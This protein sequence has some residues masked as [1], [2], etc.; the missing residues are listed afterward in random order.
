MQI[1]VEETGDCQLNIHY[2]A[3]Q[4]Q[5]LSKQKEVVS[6]FKKAPVKGFRK[7]KAPLN[8]IKNH[9]KA[10]I[11][12]SLKRALTEEAYHNTLFEKNIKAYGT[13]EFKT[14][15]L[16]KD[17]FTCEFSMRKKPDF[18]LAPFKDMEVVRPAADKTADVLYEEIMQDLRV[19]F[20]D[21]VPFDENDSCQ[22]NDNVI[23]NYQVFNGEEH[24]TAFDAEGE[25][26]TVGKSRMPGFDDALLGMKS[27]E[28]REFLLTVPED[29]T[30]PE[31]AGKTLKFVVTLVLGSK[32]NPMPL[33]D[34][35]AKKCNK[36]TFDELKSYIMSVAGA[37]IAEIAKNKLLNQLINRLVADNNIQV[38]DWLQLSE[39]QHLAAQS[40]L[41][42]NAI[43]ESLKTSFLESAT[44]NVKL[45]L[46]L[47]RVREE[48]PEAQLS[49]QEVVD[50][51]RGTMA[52]GQ[53]DVT[54][55]L[56]QM[57]QS[58]YLPILVARVRDENTLDFILNHSK[59]VE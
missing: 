9:Y 21:S 17:K 11:E 10:Q 16:Q 36:E 12:D 52:K 49:D 34:E 15:F 35:L 25:V 8:V 53:V 58:G 57:N 23:L 46:I 1:Q 29:G 26:A 32:V 5:I 14:V 2:E 47:D 51:I 6:L 3:D 22:M 38:P 4:E 28:T 54:E 31:I 39:A 13:P 27:G 20:A 59:V 30:M 37:K 42:W 48:E 24:L 56:N 41:D 44:N 43:E 33:N 19:R 55:K 18:E 50:M 40:N 45:S 7:G